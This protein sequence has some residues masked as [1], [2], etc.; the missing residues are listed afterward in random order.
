MPEG[1]IS[2]VQQ[3]FTSTSIFCSC[4]IS[5]TVLSF[6]INFKNAGVAILKSNCNEVNGIFVMSLFENLS[7][8]NCS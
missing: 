6:K 5:S 7:K 2:E 4:Y 3:K 1:M 8:T